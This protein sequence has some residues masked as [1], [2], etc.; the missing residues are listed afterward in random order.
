MNS[1]ANSD[2]VVE[3]IVEVMD[4]ECEVYDMSL[5]FWAYLSPLRRDL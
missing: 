3:R 5:F 2:Q 4:E 1:G